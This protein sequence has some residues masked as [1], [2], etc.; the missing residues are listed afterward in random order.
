MITTIKGTLPDGSKY[1]AN[2]D[3]AYVTS[4]CTVT[5]LSGKTM[6]LDVWGNGT[7]LSGSNLIN[8]STL[9][10]SLLVGDFFDVVANLIISGALTN[11]W[12]QIMVQNTLF[13][14]NPNIGSAPFYTPAQ[15]STG[16]YGCKNLADWNTLTNQ[17]RLLTVVMTQIVDAFNASKLFNHN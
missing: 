6:S 9:L 8:Q 13:Y 7:D 15:G 4:D 5:T 12:L 11:K 1:V 14:L 10:Q 16:G 17:I 3:D 2:L